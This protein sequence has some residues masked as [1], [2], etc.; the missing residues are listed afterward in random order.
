MSEINDLFPLFLFTEP[1][2]NEVILR[3]LL[4]AFPFGI[5]KLERYSGSPREER[6]GSW[7]AFSYINLPGVDPPSRTFLGWEGPQCLG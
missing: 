4:K 6:V 3:L 5:L 7:G 1:R 2:N